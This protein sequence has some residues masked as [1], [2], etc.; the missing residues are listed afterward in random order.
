MDVLH[1]PW[2]IEYILGPKKNTGNAS[3]FTQLAQSQDDAG[4]YVI[5]RSKHGFAVLNTYP[6][7]GGHCL[8]APYKQAGDLTDLDDD[9]NMDLIRL[10]LKTKKAIES[11][12]KPDG[13]NIGLNLG[14][15]A[16]AG[17]TEHLHW[18]IVP[19]W[20]GDTNF[21]PTIGQTSILPEALS[22]T[23]DKIRSAIEE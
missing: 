4:N 17:I 19:R 11:S 20:A 5:T 21:M 3:L 1:A 23:A 12:M 7:S 6:Y 15:A 22:E 9:E 2:R 18:H 13:F 14:T 8:V 10:I 16:G